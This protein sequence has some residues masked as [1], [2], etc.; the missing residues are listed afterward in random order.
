[1]NAK[2]VQKSLDN[3]IIHYIQAKIFQVKKSAFYP[4]RK[5]FQPVEVNEMGMEKEN[6]Y[7][8]HYII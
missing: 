7:D 3:R 5:P 8:F 4:R 2:I 6:L 1:M